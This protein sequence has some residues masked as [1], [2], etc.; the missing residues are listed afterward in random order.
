MLCVNC[1]HADVSYLEY[2]GDYKVHFVE[3]CIKGL[4][5]HFDRELQTEVCEGYSC[6]NPEDERYGRE[7]RE[8]G[9]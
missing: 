9:V 2:I 4:E 6:I 1:N 5:P 7:D 8:K 3:R